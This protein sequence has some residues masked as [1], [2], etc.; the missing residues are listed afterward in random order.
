MMAA[1]SPTAAPAAA[2][3][4]A[5]EAAAAAWSPPCIDISPFLITETEEES[6]NTTTATTKNKN[7]HATAL[8]LR[9][10]CQSD[11]LFLVPY[12]P[13]LAASAPRA[14][15]A[16][17]ALFALPPEAKQRLPLVS[18]QGFVRGYLPLFGESGL[19]GTFLEVK[20]GFSFGYPWGEGE[21]FAR[22]QGGPQ[23]QQQQQQQEQ[24]EGQ[25]QQKGQQ[26]QQEEEKQQ[27]PPPTPQKN[28]LQGPNAWPTDLDTLAALGGGPQWQGTFTTLFADLVAVAEALARALS[29]A[30]G[31]EEGFL[32]AG[33]CKGGETI[34]LCRAFHY[35][36]L[37]PREEGVGGEGKAAFIGSSPH[38]D[39]WV[40][41]G[42]GG[43]SLA[44]VWG[45][46]GAIDD[47]RTG[48]WR[49]CFLLG[50]AVAWGVGPVSINLPLAQG[51]WTVAPPL[52]EWLITTYLHTLTPPHTPGDL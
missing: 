25:Q 45:V 9:H 42:L 21:D 10:A 41:A 8:R 48:A 29:L 13:A 34:S 2:A 39:W 14:L 38:T 40:G 36:P 49:A 5:P 32:A 46:G 26:Q 35:L 6:T 20:E 28:P 52:N 43:A 31:R 33:V 7:K 47:I 16:A 27:Q 4:A 12:P 3:A 23:Q 24:E 18:R 17:A 51:G 11:G 50:L 19:K 37:P 1:A 22:R 15:A 44:V 30:L